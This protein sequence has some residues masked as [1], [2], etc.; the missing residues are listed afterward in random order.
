LQ[1]VLL[2]L[3]VL[4][5]RQLGLEFQQLV[6]GLQ[7]LEQLQELALMRQRYRQ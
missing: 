7:P 4:V 5:L 1:Q 3:E 6:P 2:A